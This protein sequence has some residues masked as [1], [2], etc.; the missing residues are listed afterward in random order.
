[1]DQISAELIKAGC[2]AVRSEICKLFNFIWNKVELSEEWKESIIVPVYKRGGRTYCNNYRGI[3]LVSTA[4]KFNSTC[5]ENNWGSSRIS[6]QQ[7]S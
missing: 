6:M 4:V 2:R 5:R 7:V 1:M 3:S